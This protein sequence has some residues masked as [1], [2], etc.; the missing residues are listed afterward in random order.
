MEL[1]FKNLIKNDDKQQCNWPPFVTLYANGKVFM[2]NNFCYPLYIKQFCQ[3]ERNSL[4][5]ATTACCVSIVALQYVHSIVELCCTVSCFLV[6]L[7]LLLKLLRILKYPFVKSHIH[8]CF[9]SLIGQ[10]FR[11]WC[12]IFKKQ[13][14][15]IIRVHDE[16]YAM[17]S[18]FCFSSF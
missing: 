9:N 2:P 17:I 13:I 8:L 6:H 1:E 11:K 15:T 5:I 12:N 4:Q 10:L 14:K 16:K 18:D 7:L 3:P